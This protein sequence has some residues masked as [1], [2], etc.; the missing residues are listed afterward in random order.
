M[1]TIRI[2]RTVVHI[3]LHPKETKSIKYGKKRYGNNQK[4]KQKQKCIE[5]KLFYNIFINYC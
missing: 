2:E 1:H 3:D 4:S 5:N